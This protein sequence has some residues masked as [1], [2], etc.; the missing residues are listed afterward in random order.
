MRVPAGNAA[1]CGPCAA[2]DCVGEEE[3]MAVTGVAV[4]GATGDSQSRVAYA[5]MPTRS[6]RQLLLLPLPRLV[7]TCTCWSR[8]LASP[9]GCGLLPKRG[10]IE[11]SGYA[12]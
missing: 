11:I 3:G 9:E 12:Q 2:V 7:R 1:A 8:A 4:A 6:A 5:S 10:A